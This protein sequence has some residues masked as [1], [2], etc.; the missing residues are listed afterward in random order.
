[1]ATK[2]QPSLLEAL[3]ILGLGQEQEQPKP[4][5]P[6]PA[7][8]KLKPGER[9][10][11]DPSGRT[12]PFEVTP[13]Q[14]PPYASAKGAEKLSTGGDTLTRNL[15]LDAL[16]E[17]IFGG[18]G[19]PPVPKSQYMSKEE[20]RKSELP[21]QPPQ[22]PGQLRGEPQSF[23]PLMFPGNK[24]PDTL[25]ADMPTPPSMGGVR[26]PIPG[27]PKEVTDSL[28][29]IIG[30]HDD[31]D[32]GAIIQRGVGEPPVEA[33]KQIGGQGPSFEELELQALAKKATEY[34]KPGVLDAIA[35][36]ANSLNP[37]QTP[38]GS[39]AFANQ[40]RGEPERLSAE[41]MLNQLTQARGKRQAEETRQGGQY[42]LEGLRQGGQTDRAKIGAG[43]RLGTAQINQQGG[44]A[45]EGMRGQTARDVAQIRAQSAG[46]ET[47]GQRIQAAQ[48]HALGGIQAEL[49]NVRKAIESA[50]ASLDPQVRA[51]LPALEAKRAQL[52]AVKREAVGLLHS[53]GIFTDE[54]AAMFA[55][56][57]GADIPDMS[58]EFNEAMRLYR[59][60]INKA[61]PR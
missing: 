53:A 60:Q 16:A 18:E 12:P 40:L 8:I 61:L 26:E 56:G 39:M 55:I 32:L 28:G 15:G 59:D 27:A 50:Q 19:L 4:E 23:A 45:R 38:Q 44:L 21:K 29:R 11:T 31:V 13:D 35:V 34:K 6:K 58:P 20:I 17:F 22:R 42:A 49:G 5:P 10:P 36:L 51:Q 41:R 14:N 33:V 7:P 57:E 46:R 48:F 43:A 25:R 54:E 47:P 52:D 30:P 37:R 9:I 24:P 3:Q 1:M 2:R